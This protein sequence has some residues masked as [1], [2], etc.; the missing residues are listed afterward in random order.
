MIRYIV[1]F[2]QRTDYPPERALSAFNNN[3]DIFVLETGR[4]S[5][6]TYWTDWGGTYDNPELPTVEL[7]F[8]TYLQRVESLAV[9]EA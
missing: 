8:E 1:D 2:A 4:P 5:G 9:L 3:A 6:S 7:F